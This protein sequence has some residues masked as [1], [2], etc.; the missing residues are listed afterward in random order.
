MISDEPYDCCKSCTVQ[1]ECK[2]DFD[3]SFNT[4]T[5]STFHVIYGARM[6]CLHPPQK[7]LITP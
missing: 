3:K 6:V 2:Q 7:E 5:V 1:A 4:R